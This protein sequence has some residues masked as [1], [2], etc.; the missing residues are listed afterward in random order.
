MPDHIHL[1]VQLHPTVAVSDF[2]KKLKNATHKWLDNNKEDF[3]DFQSW[4]TK[5]CALTYSERDKGVII[6]YI[7]NQREHHKN[8]STTDEIRRLLAEH[9][10]EIDE[11]YFEED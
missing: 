10:I 9:H 7:K 5:Y 6:N 2:M 1:F 8:E 4:A 11:K 3:P